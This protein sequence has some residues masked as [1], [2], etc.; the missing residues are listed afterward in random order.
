M[1]VW[2]VWRGGHLTPLLLL[3]SLIIIITIACLHPQ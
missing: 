2:I 1:R 3:L